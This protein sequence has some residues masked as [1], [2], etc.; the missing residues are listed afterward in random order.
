MKTHEKEKSDWL[1]PLRELTFPARESLFDPS[2][3]AHMYPRL[4][5]RLS[6]QQDRVDSY[7]PRLPDATVVVVTELL[8]DRPGSVP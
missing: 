7:F 8:Q 6:I 1:L 4:G 5:V 3:L 2:I